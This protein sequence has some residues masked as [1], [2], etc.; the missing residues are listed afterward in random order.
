MKRPKHT[1]LALFACLAVAGS[2]S[3][4]TY[5]TISGTATNSQPGTLFST[6]RNNYLQVDVRVPGIVPV[7]NPG[8]TTGPTLVGYS[9]YRG[10]RAW[11]ST[12]Q[13]DPFTANDNGVRIAGP[14]AYSTW[15]GVQLQDL[16][17]PADDTPAIEYHECET[18]YEPV[19]NPNQDIFSQY[20]T[21]SNDEVRFAWQIRK[22][23]PSLTTIHA[24]PNVATNGGLA[25]VNSAVQCLVSQSYRLVGDKVR[26]EMLVQNVSN[27]SVR[28]G[29]HIYINPT[30]GSGVRNG[31]RFHFQGV[32]Q[33]IDHEITFPSTNAADDPSLRRIPTFYRTFDDEAAPSVILGGLFDGADIRTT[34]LSAGPPTSAMLVDQNLITGNW[35][36]YTPASGSLIGANFGI[37]LRWAPTLVAPNSGRRF[38]TYYGLGGTDADYD[39]PY[40]LSAE[41][42][43]SLSLANGDDPNTTLVETSDN[44]YRAPNPFT[45]RASVFNTSDRAISNVAVALS[46]PAGMSLASAGDTLSKSIGL[47]PAR[48]E[49]VVSWQV[50]TTS[51][52][53]PGVRT[54]SVS[55]SGTSLTSKIVDR[56]IG[57]PALPQLLFPNVAR[58]LDMIS[59]PYDFANRDIQHVLNSLGTVGVTGGGNAAVA[60]YNAAA[61]SYGYFPDPYITSVVP[62]EGFWL[63]NGA[64]TDLRLPTDKAQLPLAQSVSVAL[65]TGWN[66]IGCPFTVPARLYDCEVVGSDGIVRSFLDA[67][68][69]GQVKPVVYE[70]QPND[71]NPTAQG[72]YLFAG[73]DATMLNPWRGYWLRSLTDVNLVFNANS[74]VGPFRSSGRS[75]LALRGGWECALSADSP[76][77]GKRPVRLGCDSTSLDGYDS[78]D[79]EAPPTLRSEGDLRLSVL[80]EDWGRDAGRYMRDIQSGTR[81]QTRWR[82]LAECDRANE[83]VTLRWNLRTVPADVQLTLVDLET[84]AQRHLRT[85]SA[86]SYNTGATPRPRLFEVIATKGGGQGLSIPFMQV[87]GTRGRAVT[88]AFGL[89][90]AATVDVVIESPTGRRVKLVAASMAATEGQNSVSWDGLDEG[91]RPVPAGMYRCRVLVS[92]P[93][94]QR[95]IA[96]RLVRIGR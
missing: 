39:Q 1:I 73:D 87:A 89:T 50:K 71:L 24:N 74:L 54:V 84:G 3:A 38:I 41:A 49:Q 72:S 83:D 43:F 94:G 59:V 30:F 85:T 6:V 19:N 48:S 32:K 29:G 45:V 23:L 78:R 42:P 64:L 9:N 18:S 61:R 22:D 56:E 91:G 4:Q 10:G 31:D 33:T 96:E 68:G 69:A 13:G 77:T 16:P 80:R 15:C 12:V 67:V 58:R 63:F 65:S 95:A 40:I 35:F 11:I 2:V 55:S 88:V 27:A 76:N 34:A 8:G 93:D 5:Q 7:V 46:L 81:A 20:P 21:A 36:A 44:V 90:S 37:M 57:I 26:V 79:V 75:P 82:L 86:F 66:Q 92:T 52:L 28:I 53:E 70:Y 62:G 25:G 60:R 14:T 47:V 51:T 17:T